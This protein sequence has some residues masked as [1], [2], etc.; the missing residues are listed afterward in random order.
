VIVSDIAAILRKAPS[1][2]NQAQWHREDS[3]ACP[4]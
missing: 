4:T 1:N 2:R 3:L